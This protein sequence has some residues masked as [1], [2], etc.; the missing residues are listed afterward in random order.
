[1]SDLDPTTAWLLGEGPAPDEDAGL[2][3]LEA[4]LP[5]GLAAATLSAVA[6][7]RAAERLEARRR[8]RRTWAFAATAAALA[9][10]A[11]FSLSPTPAVGNLDHM[12]ARGMDVENLPEVT[13]KMAVR[14]N[15]GVDRLRSDVTYR[16]GDAFF[17]RYQVTGPAQLALVRVDGAGTQLLDARGVE[18]GE[19]DLRAGGEP[20][21]WT[22]DADDG[23]A[24]YALLSSAAAP[25][26]LVAALN[27]AL[28]AGVPSA[29]A[30]CESAAM[31]GARCDAQRVEVAP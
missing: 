27:E 29:E 3:A 26:E 7:E 17:F 6:A 5:P 25:E 20:L 12:V 11:L 9:A 14:R 30:V 21:A 4:E 2:R 31:L 10:S 24:V 23:V 28:P 1:V 15:M 18:A 16:P 19:D 8:P 22:A 13:L